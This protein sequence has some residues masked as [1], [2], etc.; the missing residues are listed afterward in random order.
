MC[1]HYYMPRCSRRVLFKEKVDQP[2][3]C[4]S[5]S[6]LH[7]HIY[8]LAFICTSVSFSGFY[9]IG[10]CGEE[11]LS[12]VGANIRPTDPLALH[13]R[14]VA[15]SIARQLGAGQSSAGACDLWLGLP[16]DIAAMACIAPCMY[17]D[18]LC[19]TVLRIIACW[20]ETS[21][22]VWSDVVACGCM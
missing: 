2:S 21:T 15:V 5:L 19:F 9:T 6:T 20:I 18:L 11:L 8:A 13:Y 14:H 1:C 10:P 4:F 17:C 7:S 16:E 22:I 12:A 3:Y